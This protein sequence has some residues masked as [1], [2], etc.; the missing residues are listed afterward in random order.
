MSEKTVTVSELKTFIDAV[1]F[2]ADVEGDWMPSVRQWTRIRSMID[3]LEEVPAAPQMMQ[4]PQPQ[5]YQQPQMMQ[6]PQPT[7]AP[8]GMGG[9]GMQPPQMMNSGAPLAMHEA[10]KVRTP[11]IDTSNGKGY[12]S[13]F[14]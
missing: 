9:M 11:D 2:A 7:M 10:L 8:G 1:E 4:L 6:L 12:Q 5:H 13:A 14:A 3:R